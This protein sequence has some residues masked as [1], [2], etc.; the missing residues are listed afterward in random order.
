MSKTLFIH[1]RGSYNIYHFLIYM[2]ANLK[3]I[4]FIPDSIYIDY[5]SNHV[6]EILHTLYPYA[7]IFNSTKPPKDSIILK[8]FPGPISR[9]SGVSYGEYKYLN[10]LFT[11]ILSRYI[12]LYTYQGS[13]MLINEEF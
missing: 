10:E 11:P 5:N 7:S 4:D 12:P 13:K 2:I 6:I 3:N 1:D 8:Q 9:E